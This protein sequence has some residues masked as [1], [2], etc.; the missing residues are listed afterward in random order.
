[1]GRHRARQAEARARAEEERAAMA[2]EL[3]QMQVEEL[4]DGA[5]DLSHRIIFY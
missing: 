2:E 4:W 5:A 3:G 1:V